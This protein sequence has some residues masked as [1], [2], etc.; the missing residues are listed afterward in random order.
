MSYPTF[1]S[2]HALVRCNQ[3]GF[4]PR[5]IELVHEFG[6]V[7][8]QRGACFMVIGKRELAYAQSATGLDLSKLKGLRLVWDSLEHTVITVYRKGAGKI[9]GYTRHRTLREKRREQRRR[10]QLS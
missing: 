1:L 4:S 6:R 9:K 3:R 10:E 7:V 5:D 2:D 8:H